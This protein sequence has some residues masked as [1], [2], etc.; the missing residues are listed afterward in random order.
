MAA[1]G[2]ARSETLKI[3][4]SAIGLLVAG[5][6]GWATVCEEGCSRFDGS[7]WLLPWVFGGLW[8]LSLLIHGVRWCLG[9]AEAEQ[10]VT[11]SSEKNA[12]GPGSSS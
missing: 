12:D 9:L 5:L 4:V 11:D 1:L 8:A 10:S 7:L 2:V 3:G 6:W